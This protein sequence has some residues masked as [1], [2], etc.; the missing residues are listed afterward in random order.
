M[1]EE[2]KVGNR[3]IYLDNSNT[4]RI[5]DEVIRG[6]EVYLKE[7]Y[8]IPGGEFGHILEEEALDALEKSREIIAR[9]INAEPEEIIFTSGDVESN[10]LAI[11]GLRGLKGKKIT[12]AIEQ[13]SVLGPLKGLTELDG[14]RYEVVRLN[15]DGEGFV[16]LDQLAAEI[17][18]AKFVSIQHSNKEIGTLQDIKT[19]REVCSEQGDS[20]VF[21]TDASHSFCKTE[22]DVKKMGV[23]LL[24]LS[25]NLIHGPKGIGALYVRDGVK[26]ELKPFMYGDGRERGLWPGFIDVPSA[27]GFS[28]AVELYSEE[29]VGK[30]AKNRDYLIDELLKIEDSELNGPREKRICNNVNVSFKYIEGEALTLQANMSGLVIGTGS[31]CY[32]QGLEPSH[33]ILSI[34]KGYDMSHSST[35]VTLSRFT[36][37]AEV[38]MA[39]EIIR[40]S[41]EG[42]RKISPFAKRG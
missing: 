17:K 26:P 25:S 16:N 38:E 32:N 18:D 8:G 29:Y 10:N 13:K 5:D 27:V 39:G 19:I 33:V 30:M 12:S 7:K 40:D 23:D 15:V 22:I 11:L 37:R 42:L 20:V 4:T 21:H 35:R 31:A 6:M 9:K 41:V 14:S 28:K 24:T 34:G 36:T 1:K 3:V 2:E